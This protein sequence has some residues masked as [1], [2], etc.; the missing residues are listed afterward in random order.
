MPF[1][2]ST[3]LSLRHDIL[4]PIIRNTR[5]KKGYINSHT[6]KSITFCTKNLNSN[7]RR[8]HILTLDAARIK[9]E[10]LKQVSSMDSFLD[11]FE[12][13]ASSISDLSPAEKLFKFK[14]GLKPAISEHVNTYA[15]EDL[16]L[17]A[18]ILCTLSPF[19]IYLRNLDHL[20]DLP[21]LLSYPA[22]LML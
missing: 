17:G 11:E 22:L 16:T 8:L 13:I 9:L 12:I 3:V 7:F 14:Q 15:T 21:W 5:Y 18:A 4:L 6:L 19:A 10:K 1:F 2:S 20:F